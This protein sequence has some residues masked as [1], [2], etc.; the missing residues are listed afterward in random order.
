MTSLNFKKP[1]LL[2]GGMGRELSFRGIDISKPSW[3]AGAL[4]S[5]P[6]IVAQAHLDYIEAGA[7]IITTNTYGVIRRDLTKEGKVHLFAELN[8][9]ACRLAEKARKVSRR[10][11]KIAGSLPP[12]HGSFRPDLV[13][14]LSEILPLYE[15]QAELLAPH[16]DL[17]ICETMSS[18]QESLAAARAACR[19]S[20]PVWVSWTLHETFPGSLRSREPITGAV[21]AIRSLPVSGVLANCCSPE[22]ITRSLP[23]LAD[24]GYDFVG[25][26]AN[27]F[28]S[29]PE[30]WTLDG[31]KSTD[32]LLDLRKD[33]SPDA[34]GSHALT[35]LE[36][37]ATVI[38]GCCGTGPEHIK[39]L[40]R[41]IDTFETRE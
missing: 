9:E 40:R 5:H 20:K 36:N 14:P 27:T 24:S 22:S 25:G 35:W 7:D 34:Y 38:G 13:E 29:I 6:D 8:L 1:V 16:V 2:D 32:G 17:F 4:T 26:Y 19:F 11:I 31:D 33:L 23:D 21:K 37:G 10:D 12:L 3:S 39:E 41:I 30:N 18:I 28:T 15:E